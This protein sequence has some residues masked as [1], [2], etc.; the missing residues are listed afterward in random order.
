MGREVRRVPADWAHPKKADGEYEPLHDGLNRR[1]ADWDRDNAKWEEGFEEDFSTTPFGWKPRAPERAAMT[2]EEWDGP[3]PKA[4]HYM[5]DWPEAERTHWQMYESTSEGT[6]ISPVCASPEE[7]AHWLADN[8]AS[9]FAD[10]TATYEQWLATIQSGSALSMILAVREPGSGTMQSGVAAL[11][12]KEETHERVFN[13]ARNAFIREV[14]ELL[15][16]P[17]PLLDRYREHGDPREAIAEMRLLAA[18][19]GLDFDQL[20]NEATEVE[21][22][23]FR[24]IEAGEIKPDQPQEPEK[25]SARS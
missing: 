16:D 6:P 11:G 10:M 5:P 1:L 9:A 8:G 20:I 24:A 15:D 7:L 19:L 14:W 13:Y 4:E 2:F 23:R 21:S 22:V 17:S 25:S 12:D 18:E 3:R